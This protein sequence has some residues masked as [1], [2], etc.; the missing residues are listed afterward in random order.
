MSCS[1]QEA[2]SSPSGAEAKNRAWVSEGCPDDGCITETWPD[3][4]WIT[5]T[6]VLLGQQEEGDNNSNGWADL[7]EQRDYQRQSSSD[8]EEYKSKHFFPY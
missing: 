1:K 2:D 7:T 5:E 4:G 3:G 8:E 6:W